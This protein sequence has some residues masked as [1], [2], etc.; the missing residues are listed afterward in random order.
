VTVS[1]S[2]TAPT[3]NCAQSITVTFTATDACGN[4]AT[5][6]KSFTVDD[7]TAP[8]ITAPAPL[9]LTCDQS[10]DHSAA[11]TA[12]LSSASVADNC[13]TDITIT[14]DYSSYAQSCGNVITVKFNAVD[15]CGNAALEVE[16]TLTFIDV[17]APVITVPE[18]LVL[19]CDQS[20]DHAA[21]ISGW[22]ASAA[23]SDECDQ[24]VTISHDYTGY[25]QACG[26]VITVT[27]TATDDCN[28]A[29][30]AT[31]SIR[32]TDDVAPVLTA[33][34]PL[35]L[36]CEPG[37][38][39]RTIIEDWLTSASFT[40][41]CDLELVIGNDY[42]TYN[43]GCGENIPV[44]FTATDACGNEA[45][46]VTS[47]ITFIDE[48]APVIIAPEPL[49]VT[50]N[51][52][53]D[54]SDVI[55]AWLEE[56][57]VSDNCDSYITVSNDF[58]T[59]TQG[60]GQEI[61]VMFMAQ[62]IC[63]N[64]AEPVTSTITFTDVTAPVITF[65]PEDLTLEGDESTDPAATGFATAADDCDTAP[66]VTY[67]DE[68]ID[69][70]IA[71]EYTIERTWTATDAC[72]NTVSCVQL[73]DI[74]DT[75]P[76]VIICPM[77]PSTI[78]VDWDICE[79]SGFDLGQPIVSDNVST[80]ANIEVYSNK[81]E[82]FPV[83]ITTVIWT[84]V[85]EAGNTA[86]CEQLVIVPDVYDVDVPTGFSPNGDGIND[87]F[88]ISGMCLYPEARMEIFSRWGA[89]VYEK[90][91]Y[92]NTD[93]HGNVDAWWDGRATVN[94]SRDEILPAGTYYYILKLTNSEMRK[95]AVYI[96]R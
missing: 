80:L 32:F 60:C 1:A 73:I 67:A 16:S 4:T 26:Q 19:A 13:D 33:P 36:E 74:G 91:R 82:S 9:E 77:Q 5:E 53:V 45:L 8:A 50:C 40:D 21:A 24:D 69:G 75:T 95:G 6:T 56:A 2:Y 90:D 17:T 28:N 37:T 58:T 88:R 42:E 68:I 78:M 76:P 61:T 52:A 93:V 51:Q 41:N 11:I 18:E 39:Y 34:N 47:T 44:T 71:V 83:G 31:S 25:T 55:A 70:A 20:T 59:Y 81:P 15:D 22:L 43:Q 85:D 65:C 30:T 35:I 23:A 64:D 87:Y 96:N 94:G 10:V 3:G 79:A 92:G 46:P 49:V 63:G 48:V 29:S 27:F 62:D 66:V 12:W 38:D 89:K 14:N 86:T 7:K 54:H 57:V 72:G 84:A